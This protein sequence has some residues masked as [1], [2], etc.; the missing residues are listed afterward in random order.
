MNSFL[1]GFGDLKC[2]YRWI[3][4]N[5]IASIDCRSSKKSF[6][7]CPGLGIE[8]PSVLPWIHGP[9]CASGSHYYMKHVLS[10]VIASQTHL[11]SAARQSI[12]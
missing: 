4:S 8:V 3:F 6:C 11:L 5:I 2:L 12:A 10:G 7:A 9:Q 1:D